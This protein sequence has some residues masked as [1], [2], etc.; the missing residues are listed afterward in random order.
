MTSEE[1]FGIVKQPKDT[2]PMIDEVI[3]YI[4]KIQSA[5]YRHE[6]LDED[7][8]R[9]AVNDVECFVSGLSE[10]MEIIRIN[11]DAIRNWGNEWKEKAKELNEP[12]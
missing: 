11:T 6:K 4:D 8:L 5:V 7:R 3:R 9:S 12:N 1:K 10:T 2:C